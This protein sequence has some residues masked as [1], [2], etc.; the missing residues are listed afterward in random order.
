V[1]SKLRVRSSKLRWTQEED[2]L[3]HEAI[4]IHGIPNWTKIASHVKT[5]NNKMCSQRWKHSLRPEMGVVKKGKWTKE[6]DDKLRQVKRQH[7]G[8]P[9]ASLWESVSKGMQFTRNSKQCRERW[10]NFLDPTLRFDCWTM[11]EDDQILR[12]HCHFGNAWKK[13]TSSLPGRSSEHIR[14]RFLYLTDHKV[15]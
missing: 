13:M 15:Q 8:T 4:E 9:V 5:R 2:K 1:R 6:E 10:S 14:R 7:E 11:A 3:L 12:L